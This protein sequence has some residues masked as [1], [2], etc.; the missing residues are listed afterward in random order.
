MWKE[1]AMARFKILFWH[2]FGGIEETMKL[3]V[4]M[5]GVLA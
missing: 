1:G 2:L 3:S 5:V 4:M